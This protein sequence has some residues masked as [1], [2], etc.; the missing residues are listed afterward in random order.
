LR[1]TQIVNCLL[2]IK[3]NSKCHTS[4]QNPIHKPKFFDRAARSV[5][6]HVVEGVNDPLLPKPAYIFAVVL[7]AC[8][9]AGPTVV[10]LNWESIY[11]G[12]ID[13]LKVDNL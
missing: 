6:V 10:V 3:P 8:V 12:K 1:L 4:L 9:T 13:I 7:Q 2:A 11:M 5:P